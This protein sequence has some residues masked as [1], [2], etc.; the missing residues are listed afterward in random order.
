MDI[1]DISTCEKFVMKVIWDSTED[2]ALQD[3]MGKVNE[4]NEKSWKPQTVSTFL[5][6]LVKKGF[7]SMYRKGRY[8]YYKPLVSKREFWK[9]TVNEDVRMFSNGDAE[10]FVC[11]LCD[12]MLSKEDIIKLKKKLDELS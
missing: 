4:E 1:N 11:C 7:L 6:R 12:E 5:S 9:A 2:L 8:C 3:I 10:D